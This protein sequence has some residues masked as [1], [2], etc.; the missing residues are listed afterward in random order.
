MQIKPTAGCCGL[1]EIY[2]LDDGSKNTLNGFVDVFNDVHLHNGLLTFALFT[3]NLD[4]HRGTR[5]AKYI[6]KH[7]LG[8]ITATKGLTNPKSERQIMCWI[9]AIDWDALNKWRSEQKNGKEQN[10]TP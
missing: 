6:T 8:I 5:L 10:R 4:S 1:Y 9:W 3:D 2:E 7:A